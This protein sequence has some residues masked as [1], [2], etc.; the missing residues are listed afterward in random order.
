MELTL[1]K[2]DWYT[3]STEFYSREL[4]GIWMTSYLLSQ[5]TALVT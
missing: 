2:R 5:L 1:I 3:S 4:L